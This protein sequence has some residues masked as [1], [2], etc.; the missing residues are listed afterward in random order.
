L[1]I[2]V[3]GV[4]QVA[5]PS[6]ADVIDQHIDSAKY[7]HGVVHYRLNAGRLTEVSANGMNA[8]RS[9]CDGGDLAVGDVERRLRPPAQGQSAALGGKR[10]GTRESD[11]AAR[12]GDDGDFVPQ[13]QIHGSE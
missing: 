13:F 7:L 4:E 3:D 2:C 8:V 11:P 1:P 6:D 9:S 5:T 12:S 10:F